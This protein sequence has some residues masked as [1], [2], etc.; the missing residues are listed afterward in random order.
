[1]E[2]WQ[3]CKALAVGWVVGP[4]HSRDF[5]TVSQIPTFMLVLSKGDCKR[6][7]VV[8]EAC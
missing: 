5:E 1:M 4:C 2:D 3:G 8:V 7:Q 6:R